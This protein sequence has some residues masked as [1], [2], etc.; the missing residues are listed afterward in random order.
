MDEYR[1]EK[2]K[3]LREV[4]KKAINNGATF[5]ALIWSGSP[6]P[7]IINQWRDQMKHL[8]IA[9]GYDTGSARVD[10]KQV[11]VQAHYN[12]KHTMLVTCEPKVIEGWKA[13]L[14]TKD[15]YA[16]P[17]CIEDILDAPNEN[18]GGYGNFTSIGRQHDTS[19]SE[20]GSQISHQIHNIESRAPNLSTRNP[21]HPI[22][23]ETTDG[24][25]PAKIRAL[26]PRECLALLGLTK[27]ETRKMLYEET[28]KWSETKA[29]MKKRFQPQHGTSCL[30]T[31]SPTNEKTDRFSRKKSIN[32]SPCTQEHQRRRRIH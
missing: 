11:Q 12:G 17:T 7:F 20:D 8:A 2:G 15:K 23:I 29:A 19:T 31:A 30:H 24:H 21:D 16:K 25:A 5:T 26:R 14:H 27:V 1:N 3:A 22:I 13:S 28:I 6:P 9:T 18:Y 10:G 4:I 32:S